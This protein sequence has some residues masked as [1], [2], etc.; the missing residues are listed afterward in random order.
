MAWLQRETTKEDE[1]WVFCDHMD[2]SCVIYVDCIVVWGCIILT[3]V[4][5]QVDP[6]VFR[7]NCIVCLTKVDSCKALWV[8][9]DAQFPGHAVWENKH[10]HPQTQINSCTVHVLSTG[11]ASAW[12]PK[13]G[14]LSVFHA[15]RRV[16]KT[17]NYHRVNNTRYACGKQFYLKPCLG[18]VDLQMNWYF[19]NK[20]SYYVSYFN[21]KSKNHI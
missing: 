3:F 19:F 16:R 10:T 20:L 21:S 8:V 13:K 18:C 6:T 12:K 17:Q 14:T 5:F 15:R 11:G 2:V 4:G 1:I 9:A 7:S